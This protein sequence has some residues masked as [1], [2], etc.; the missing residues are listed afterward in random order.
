MTRRTRTYVP[1]LILILVGAY[2][3]WQI[4]GG[5][6]AGPDSSGCH[7]RYA[8]DGNILSTCLAE[9]EDCLAADGDWSMVGS[10]PHCLLP[11]LDG[12]TP[13]TDSTECQGECIADSP[14][15]TVGACSAVSG[16]VGCRIWMSQGTPQ[17]VCLD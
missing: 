9:Y 5:S 11:T 13:C 8:E 10:S 4:G 6:L 2:V 14:I 15:A 1:L 16:A 17:E 7:D 3:V 12:G